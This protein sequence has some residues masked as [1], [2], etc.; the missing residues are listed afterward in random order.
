MDVAN[1]S[2]FL[3]F[4]MLTKRPELI[5]DRIA[6]AAGLSRLPGNCIA[7]TSISDQRTAEDY[8]GPLRDMKEQ[9]I[10]SAVFMSYEPAVGPV[11]WDSLRLGAWC[12]WVIVGG[13]SSAARQ[14]PRN[15][16]S[17]PCR[18]LWIEQAVAACE[19]ARVPVFVKQFGE[20]SIDARGRR[21]VYRDSKG[22]N[23]DEWPEP[24]RIRQRLVQPDGTLFRI[25]R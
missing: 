24:L 12:D 9:G 23:P 8:A 22:G 15:P 16:A 2:A 21:V 6:E 4:L 3:R 20:V 18:Q 5:R 19:V 17:R 11:R 10:A 25:A 14:Y 13:E 1:A 7:G